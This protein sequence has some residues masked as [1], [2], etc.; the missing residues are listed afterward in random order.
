MPVAGSWVGEMGRLLPPPAVNCGVRPSPER[1]WRSPGHRS[2][3]RAPRALGPVTRRSLLGLLA[4]LIRRQDAPAAVLTTHELGTAAPATR[5]GVP[6]PGEVVEEGPAEQTL[7]VPRHPFTAALLEAS[8]RG[9]RG[10]TYAPERN[11]DRPRGRTLGSM[12]DTGVTGQ[13]L[14]QAVSGAPASCRAVLHGHG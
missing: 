11:P 10:P 6:G 13:G 1:S 8:Q 7:P 3:T 5:V 2:A 4:A 12:D 14:H 9:A